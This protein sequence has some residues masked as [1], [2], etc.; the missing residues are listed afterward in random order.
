MENVSAITFVLGRFPVRLEF[1]LASHIHLT[2]T[3][4]Q[5][6]R[7]LTHHKGVK[8]GCAEGD[9]GA[10]T[11]VLA[12]P[13]SDGTFR[14]F[15]VDSCLLFMP[16]LHGKWLLTVEDLC[17]PEGPLHPVQQSMVDAH[18]AQCGYCTPGIV[19]SLFALYKNH[20]Q[21]SR[22]TID[23]AL[24]GNLCRCTG[25]R[26][27]V[28]AASRACVHGGRDSLTAQEPNVLELL[29][30]LPDDSLDLRTSDQRYFRPSTLT[31][32]LRVRAGHPD[33][34]V[35]AGA[36]DT[37][38]RVTKQ[39]EQLQKVLDLSGVPELKE[40]RVQD[41]RVI[42]GAGLPLNRLMPLVRERLPALY[43][44]LQV[45][46]SPQIRNLA[47]LG[48]NLGTAS[49]IGDTL[50][51][52]MA[53]GAQVTVQSRTGIRTLPVEQFITGYRTTACREDEL[54]TSVE[55][56]KPVER[57][58]IRSYKVSKRKDLDISS[59]SAAFRLTLNEHDAVQDVRLV[60]GGMART[61]QR[62]ARTENF[63]R[64]R[65]WD[66]NTV[67]RAVESVDGD[68][69]PIS[70]V[71]ASAEF[72]RVAARNLLLKFWQETSEAQEGT[73]V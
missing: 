59:V 23:D 70:D 57:T 40:F 2:T 28:E 9:C 26:P 3:V 46:G 30:S 42:V 50:P 49:P 39:H 4:L 52:L 6:L 1:G 31:E 21:P 15:A 62:A 51:V 65:S 27:I 56:P 18:G 19:M 20:N 68:F 8:E 72:R 64:G 11:A 22:E 35:I 71:R 32:A 7:S 16:M 14:Y 24:T 10:C 73:A 66:R 53:Y 60:F 54:I 44:M 12:E 47:T 43:D 17:P 29:R 45:F 34:V 58:W 36:T 55:I 41:D 67:E 48:G 37:A 61:T 5:Y 25:Y 38:L 69:N 63:L 13:Q 33:A